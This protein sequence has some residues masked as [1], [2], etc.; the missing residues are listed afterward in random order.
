MSNRS[1]VKASASTLTTVCDSFDARTCWASGDGRS[2][3]RDLR[4]ARRPLPTDCDTLA[5]GEAV[6]FT[7]TLD[8]TGDEPAE[9]I[10][11]YRVH[12]AGTARPRR[13]KVFK[14][15]RRC[16][17]PGRPTTITRRHRFEHASIRR[18]HPGRHT[19]DIQVNGYDGQEFSSQTLTAEQVARIV[20]R[21]YAFGVTG[22]CPTLTTNSFTAFERGM[23]AIAAA[24]EQDAEIGRR[25]VGIHL[26]GPYMSRED[27]PRGAH[28]ME[29]CRR[30]DWDEFC[31]L[32][33]RDRKC[34]EHRQ[35]LAVR[36]RE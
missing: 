36:R 13:P 18:I 4:R 30:P 17:E 14:L 25:V 27:G 28:P 19:I 7:L 29:H 34:V 11:D 8:Q 24:C 35:G 31:R 3:G 32:Q 2:Q 21:H 6:T 10:I 23:R 26:E 15:T 22:I 16:L 12:H 20:R 1:C 5:I 9:A 33:E